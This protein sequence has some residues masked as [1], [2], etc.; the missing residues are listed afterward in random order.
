M[1]RCDNCNWKGPDSAL[2]F[3]LHE[4]T[5]LHERLEPGG[6]VPAG[7]CPEC[8]CLAYRDK[9]DA[10]EEEAVY[11]C[12]IE[13]DVNAPAGNPR[14]AAERA[15]GLLTA[16]DAMRPVVRVETPRQTEEIDLNEEA[17]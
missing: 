3:Q 17:E 5:N 13:I 2:L 16:H 11:R 1:C 14:A 8:R 15:W 12:R 9:L 7:E 4:L 6:E 10:T